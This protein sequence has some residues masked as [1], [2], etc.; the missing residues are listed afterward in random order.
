VTV[1]PAAPAA[2]AL[3]VAF[4]LRGPLLLWLPL[5][6]LSLRRLSLLRRTLRTR[7]TLLVRPAS[8]PT[9][10]A[11]LLRLAVAP[12]LQPGLLLAVAV[13]LALTVALSVATAVTPVLG[14]LVAPL[15]IASWRLRRG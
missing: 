11:A 7:W 8:F 4:V 15:L 6:R 9:I 1:A 2:A 5:L 14:P 12:L 10:A 3:L 13:L